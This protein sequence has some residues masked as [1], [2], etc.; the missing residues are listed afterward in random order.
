MLRWVKYPAARRFN[1]HSTRDEILPLHIYIYVWC[2]DMSKT[3]NSKSAVHTVV[4][5]SVSYCEY[6]HLNI[7]HVFMTHVSSTRSWWP[8]QSLCISEQIRF[9]WEVQIFREVQNFTWCVAHM[10]PVCSR[11]NCYDYNHDYKDNLSV[12]NLYVG[13]QNLL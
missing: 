8:G 2:N 11:S 13:K 6:T 3:L 1:E 5:S 4:H 7:L 10:F 9:L 12:G